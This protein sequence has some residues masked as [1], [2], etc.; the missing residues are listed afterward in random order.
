MKE[1][2]TTVIAPKILEVTEEQSFPLE[3]VLTKVQRSW[4]LEKK[5]PEEKKMNFIRVYK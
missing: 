3:A 5:T 1:R 2:E 4:Y